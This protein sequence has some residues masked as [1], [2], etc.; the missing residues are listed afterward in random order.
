MEA[1]VGQFGLHS[2]FL[3]LRR[4]KFPYHGIVGVITD[5]KTLGAFYLAF[6]IYHLWV[7]FDEALFEPEAWPTP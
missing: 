4:S 7:L 6:N 3:L 2:N 5:R 1:K